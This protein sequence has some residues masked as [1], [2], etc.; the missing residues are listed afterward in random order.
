MIGFADTPWEVFSLAGIFFSG[1]SLLPWMCRV[2]SVQ[3]RHGLALYL[4]HSLF[5]VIYILY[6][7][8]NPADTIN[9][10]IL[11][12]TWDQPPALGTRFV[13]FFNSFLT[14]GLGLS[15]GGSFFVYNILGS[16]GLI[17][18]SAAMREAFAGKSRRV[19]Q[20][21]AILPFLPG[22]SFWSTAIGKDSIAFFSVG[23]IC[24]AAASP[25]RRFLAILIGIVALV[26]VRPHMAGF[27]MIALA[28][29]FSL[30]REGSLQLKLLISSLVLPTAAAIGVI[31]LSYIGL[32][33]LDG[34]TEYVDQRQS[35]NTEGGSSIDIANAS[36]P[37]R[38]FMFVFRPLFFDAGGGLGLIVSFE[39]LVLLGLLFGT[40]VG[41][42]KRDSSLTRFQ[43]VFFL[44]YVAVSWLALANITANM[45]I[46]IRQKTMF[47][48]MLLMLMLS[49]L[50]NT[51]LIPHRTP[52]VV[53]PTGR[54][55]NLPGP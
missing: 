23:L 42:I 27:L 48:P 37:M 9:Y 39:N 36:V 14:Q 35:Y 53:P 44:I 17:A 38:M 46:A 30:I 41:V 26:A 54:P 24:W 21:I 10:F 43:R 51:R 49:Y 16:I 34:L 6:S 12:L 18:F 32:E 7:M 50:P 3:L 47:T 5:C 13:I 2:L 55:L 29:A 8:G 45:G 20:V 11:S 31:S 25:Y 19:R 1:L 4:W 52:S 15:Y 40:L 33:E 22:F 28:L